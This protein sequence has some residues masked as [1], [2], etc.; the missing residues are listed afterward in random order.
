MAKGAGPRSTWAVTTHDWSVDVDRAH[1]LVAR[2]LAQSLGEGMALH[3][4]LPTHL[5][6]AAAGSR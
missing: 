4:P 3:L 2:E 5:G 1:L 6:N